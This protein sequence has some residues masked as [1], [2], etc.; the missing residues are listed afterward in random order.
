MK[1]TLQDIQV[2]CDE[3]ITIL[4]DNT[5]AI[6][7]SKNTMMHSKMKHIPIKYHFLQ[8]HAT[9]KNTKLEYVRKKDQITNIFTK[10]LARET[11]EYLLQKLGIV[12]AP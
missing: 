10:P 11:F 5:N 2:K 1:Q 12:F 4:C 9:E 3:P 6:G 7:I 8:K